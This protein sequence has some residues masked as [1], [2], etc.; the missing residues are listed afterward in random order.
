MCPVVVLRKW[1][2]KDNTRSFI[3]HACDGPSVISFIIGA[4]MSHMLLTFQRAET[5]WA[6]EISGGQS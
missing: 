4:Q 6:C 3:R 1:K 2:Y 5:I